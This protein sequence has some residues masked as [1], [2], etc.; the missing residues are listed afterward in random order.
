MKIRLSAAH[1]DALYDQIL[2]RLSGIGDV[3]L[4]VSK[5]DYETATKLGRE[6]SDD[7][8]L[9]LDDLGWGAGPGRT[10]ELKTPPDVLRRVFGRL[11]ELAAG[12]RQVTDPLLQEVRE[13]E[14]RTRLVLEAC[15]DVLRNLDTGLGDSA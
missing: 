9:V 3:W 12:R 8:R 11:E 5:E 10:I 13:L 2:D 1:R 15:R 4:A 7:L 14:E 6:F